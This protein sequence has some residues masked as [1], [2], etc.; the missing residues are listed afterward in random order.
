MSAFSLSVTTGA[1]LSAD[2]GLN[3]QPSEPKPICL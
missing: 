3:A 2:R 1:C